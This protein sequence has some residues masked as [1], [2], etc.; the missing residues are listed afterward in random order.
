MKITRDQYM[1]GRDLRYPGSC[2][3]EIEQNAAALLD[4][5]NALL[6]L[7]A[8]E[9]IEP[10][11]DE[12]GSYV[13]SGF[14]PAQVNDVTQN[15]AANSTHLVGLGIDLRDAGADRALARWCLKEARPGGLL[16]QHGLYMERPQWTPTWVHLQL[17][18][19]K[20]GRR[21]YVPSSKPPI[22][23]ALPEEV[24]FVI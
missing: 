9:G 12:Q 13:A 10:V 20:S 15:A 19:P 23:A 4:Q 21:V 11:A 14:R 8:A 24:E 2:T 22:V 17:K 16:D 5:V 18:N 3:E 6:E 1:M 7:A